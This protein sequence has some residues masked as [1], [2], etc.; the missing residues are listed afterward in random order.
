M[1]K[2]ERYN[3]DYYFVNKKELFLQIDNLMKNK[4]RYN[5]VEKVIKLYFTENFEFSSKSGSFLIKEE[6]LDYRDE[7]G[8]KV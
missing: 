4:I 8:W 7:A 3:Q 6:E 1:Y 2:L 5:S